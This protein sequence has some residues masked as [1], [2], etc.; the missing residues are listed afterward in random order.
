M[1]D[2]VAM[3]AALTATES[4]RVDEI[5][6]HSATVEWLADRLGTGC[7]PDNTPR[8]ASYVPL[9]S[10]IFAIRVIE[11]ESFSPGYWEGRDRSGAAIESGT[12]F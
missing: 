4:P 10:T 1:E 12:F 2:L 7:E 8:P 9:T 6:M 3:Y 11:D 5:R